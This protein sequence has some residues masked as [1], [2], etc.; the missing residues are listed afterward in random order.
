MDFDSLPSVDQLEKE[1][2][3]EKRKKNYGRALRSTLF[4]LIVVAAAA[5]LVVVIFL[6][7]IQI[8]GASMSPTLSNGD[9]L[10]AAN[11]KNYQNGDIIAFYYNNNL[12][13]KRAVA[14][15]GDKVDID[16]DGYVYVNGS[17]LREDY[18]EDADLGKC[19]L[20]F[21]FIVPEESYFVMG[22]NRYMS[23]DSRASSFGCI[24]KNLIAG[25]IIFRIWPFTKLGPIR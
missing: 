7:V 18:I 16:K 15:G 25:K 6:P 12:M 1:L 21:P 22:D 14:V 13:V 24:D 4:T 5:I 9:V 10:M 19:D 8:S 17:M 11:I 3:R 2:K 23:V 20:D